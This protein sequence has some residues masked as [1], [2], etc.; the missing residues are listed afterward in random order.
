MVAHVHDDDV[1]RQV[2]HFDRALV[3]RP[4]ALAHGV[5]GAGEPLTTGMPVSIGHIA[6]G[7]VRLGRE[8]FAGA[9]LLYERGAVLAAEVEHV[10]GRVGGVGGMAADALARGKRT[11]NRGI[12]PER[13]DVP[14]IEADP[15][16]G[17]VAGGYFS[18][19]D[20]VVRQRRIAD[21]QDEIAP[22]RPFSVL[23]SGYGK[24]KRVAGVLLGEA[25][26]FP[27]REIGPAAAD[28]E[29]AALAAPDADKDAVV[30]FRQVE[31]HRRDAGRNGD[32]DVVGIDVGKKVFKRG[33]SRAGAGQ[34]A[35]SEDDKPSFHCA[36]SMVLSRCQAW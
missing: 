26:P 8:P 20:A 9:V 11:F 16:V 14:L 7:L 12:L 22:L 36:S 2:E 4:E 30:I 35:G 21:I 6:D 15:A 25:V 27:D 24:V 3:A 31:I 19:N 32:A 18:I 13:M 28:L 29:F 10:L 5:D 33:A 23:A 17:G 34:Q 1:G